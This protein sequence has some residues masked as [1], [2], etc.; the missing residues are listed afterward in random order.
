MAL[1]I[2]VA[3]S[4]G[5]HLMK[6]E[7]EKPADGRF[8]NQPPKN[9]LSNSPLR[10]SLPQSSK[11]FGLRLKPHIR[12]IFNSKVKTNRLKLTPFK[13]GG[14][15]KVPHTFAKTFAKTFATKTYAV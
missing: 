13:R 10:G 15:D 4:Y 11:M 3:P 8:Y 12:V 2:K 1:I 7:R 6:D 14:A 9:C 5:W